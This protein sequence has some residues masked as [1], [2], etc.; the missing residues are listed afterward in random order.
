MRFLK[1]DPKIMK[2]NEIRIQIQAPPLRFKQLFF[3]YHKKKILN[4]SNNHNNL[5]D[6][7]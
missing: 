3:K 5:Q 4:C 7:L 6:F 1:E 2:I